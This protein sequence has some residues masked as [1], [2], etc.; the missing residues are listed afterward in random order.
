MVPFILVPLGDRIEKEFVEFGRNDGSAHAGGGDLAVRPLR[1][2]G[3]VIG[4]PVQR[5]SI[6]GFQPLSMELFLGRRGISYRCEGGVMLHSWARRM[7]RNAETGKFEL[8]M[9]VHCRPKANEAN[10]S[11][12][13]W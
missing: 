2:N 9:Y 13:R 6:L 1:E 11:P 10:V 5:R 4:F 3:V 8:G 12:L 7:R